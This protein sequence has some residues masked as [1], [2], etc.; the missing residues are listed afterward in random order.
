MPG[1]GEQRFSGE[2]YELPSNVLHIKN[3][4]LDVPER[5]S[6]AFGRR[7]HVPVVGTADGAALTATLV[8]VGEGRHR[9]FLDGGVRRAIGKVPGDQV[10]IRVR[11]DAS[12]RMPGL[13][14][15]LEAALREHD[16]LAAWKALRPSRRKE[17]L[18][19]LA[20]AKRDTTRV[21]RIARIVQVALDEGSVGPPAG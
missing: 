2:L 21:K 15:D 17:C 5:V 12:D 13:P 18:V 1:T 16:A 10:E 9:L 3:V 7:G 4:A 14:A 11:V 6:R 8:P 19:A 20:D